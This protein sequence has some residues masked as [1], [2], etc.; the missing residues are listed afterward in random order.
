[1]K[2]PLGSFGVVFVCSDSLTNDYAALKVEKNEG[3]NLMSLDRETQILE[4]L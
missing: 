4:G 2:I 1:M 3:D